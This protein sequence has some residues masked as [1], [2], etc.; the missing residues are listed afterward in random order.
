MIMVT[1]KI[2]LDE[3]EIREEFIRASGPGGLHVNRSATTVQL[4]F[5]AVYSPSL[6]ERV[7]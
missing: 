2:V 4:R 3:S 1:A 6:P 7:R 5:D